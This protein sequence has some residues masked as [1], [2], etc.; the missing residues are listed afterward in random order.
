MRIAGMI[1][2]A[3]MTLAAG[4]AFGQ[5]LAGSRA[6]LN[7]THVFTGADFDKWYG[8]LEARSP[9]SCGD[10][11]VGSTCKGSPGTPN[12]QAGHLLTLFTRVIRNSDPPRIMP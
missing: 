3:A 7:K 11:P 10:A 8:E 1:A 6:P 4:G 9:A 5:N 2:L 12:I